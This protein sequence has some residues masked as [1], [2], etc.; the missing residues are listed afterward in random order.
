MEPA[1]SM[2]LKSFNECKKIS[3]EMVASKIEDEDDDDENCDDEEE[4]V[5][6]AANSPLSIL[7]KEFLV[8]LITYYSYW[9]YDQ[10]I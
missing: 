6:V 4:E 7:Q 2:L 10:Y 9:K 3:D 8:H 5:A 1:K